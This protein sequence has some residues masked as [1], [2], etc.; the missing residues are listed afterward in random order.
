VYRRSPLFVIVLL[1]LVLASAGCVSRNVENIGSDE[2]ATMAPPPEPIAQVDQPASLA[3]TPGVDGN[4]RLGPDVAV[5]PQGTLFVIVR[6][7]GRETG[8][9]LAVKQLGGEVPT[10]FR[11]TEENAMIPGTPFVGDLDLIVRLD[12]DGNAFSRQPG[13][14]EGRAGPVQAGGEVEILLEPAAL[15]EGGNESAAQ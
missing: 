14:L 3:E 11:I 1:A 5:V 2:A 10:S 12:Q 7:S 9:P 8:P 6:V 15:D 4:I 13:D